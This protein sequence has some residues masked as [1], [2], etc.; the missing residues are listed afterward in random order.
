MVPGLLKSFVNRFFRR[1]SLESDLDAELQSHLAIEIRQRI[2]RGESA[3][4]A[5]EM[6]SR[7]FGNK[8]LIAEVT[9]HVGIRCL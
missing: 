2:E 9:R 5:R 1:A 3:Q 7:E 4:S 8:E 6:A